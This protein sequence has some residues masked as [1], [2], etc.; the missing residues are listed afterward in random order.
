MGSGLG[1]LPRP[2]VLFLQIEGKRVEGFSAPNLPQTK[3][4]Y[5]DLDLFYSSKNFRLFFKP[6]DKNVLLVSISKK[7]FRLAVERNKIKRRIREIFRSSSV[8]GLFE[9]MIV[10]SVFKPFGE[11][12][13]SKAVIEIESAVE[14]LVNRKNKK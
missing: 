1:C 12:S 13:Y 2:G 14:L 3:F 10:F 4:K 5:S 11:L 7:N 9:G 8:C 6:L